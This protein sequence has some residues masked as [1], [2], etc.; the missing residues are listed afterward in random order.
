MTTKA[1]VTL[2]LMLAS[3][4]LRAQE[5]VFDVHVHLRDG[6]TSLKAYQADAASK[7]ITLAGV[8]AMWFGG[9]NAAAQGDTATMQANN[10][11]VIALAKAHPGTLAV[12]TVHPYDGQAALDE[13][14]RVAT[15]G[16]KLLKLH[17]HTQRFDAADPR[18]LAL[19]K[20]AGA[21][22]VTVLMD[23]ANILPGDSERQFNLAVQASGT[24]FIF[25]HM[26]AANFR[27][28]NILKLARTA[29]GFAGDNIYFDISATVLLAVDSPIEAEFV[30]T[31]R[32]V[33]IDR[34]LLGSDYPQF[35]IAETV[36]ALD[37]LDLRADER[38]KIRSGNAL[39]LFGR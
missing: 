15:R 7:N 38:S 32:N 14:V 19:V 6:E 37:R 25:A 16:V 29:S 10:D 34:V 28:W 18:V 35:S 33:G 8:G 39:R 2:M 27:F 9:P 4:T 12:A 1:L 24:R 13:V 26:G 22:D 3:Q 5:P 31:L 36:D 21:S 11:S 23:N 30:W 17:P 20:Q